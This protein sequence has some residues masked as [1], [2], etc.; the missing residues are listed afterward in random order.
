MAEVSELRPRALAFVGDVAP[1]GHFLS[2]IQ[3]TRRLVRHA[4]GRDD[5]VVFVDTS[6]YVAGRLAEKL[7]LA[8]LAVLSTEPGSR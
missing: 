2:V 6:G 1:T 3:G 4:L 8:K 5:D 7:K